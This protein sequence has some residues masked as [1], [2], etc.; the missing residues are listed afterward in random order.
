MGSR[1][2]IRLGFRLGIRLIRLGIR[3]IRLGIRLIHFSEKCIKRNCVNPPTLSLEGHTDAR[4][5]KNSCILELYMLY[6]AK[7]ALH[8]VCCTAV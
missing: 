3:L 1:L 7:L 8:A 2:I 5:M 4:I 6:A